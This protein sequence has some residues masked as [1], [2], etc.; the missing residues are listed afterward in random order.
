MALG[1][2]PFAVKPPASAAAVQQ[3]AV[4][5]QLNAIVHSVHLVNRTLAAT[6][7]GAVS[8]ALADLIQ[9]CLQ[10]DPRRRYAWPVPLPLIVL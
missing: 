9:G 6:P 7:N 10:L 2:V 4:S 1:R 3:D 5:S 8:D